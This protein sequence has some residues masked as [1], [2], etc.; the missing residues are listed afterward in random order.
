MR[1]FNTSVLCLLI[2]FMVSAGV[3]AQEN[4]KSIRGKV[5]S[6]DGEELP[7]VSIRVKNSNKG[8]FSDARGGFSIDLTPAEGTLVFTYVGFNPKEVVIENQGF[9][10]VRL[11]VSDEALDEVVVI[12]YGTV[13]K[14]DLTG[15]V[16]S[17]K[18]DQIRAM[19]VTSVDQALQGRAAGVQVVQ[20]S[21]VP[22]GGTNIRVR[23]TTSVNA[24]SEPLYVIDGMLINN[25]Q[26]EMAIENRGPK[27][28]P[29]SSLNP[30]DI[31]SI[32]IL[33]DA[34]ATAIYGSRGAN[35]VVLITTKKGKTGEGQISLDVYYG[36]QQASEKLELLN[37]EQ[38]A[39]LVNEANINAG[40]NPVYV[41]PSTL[42]KGT[43]WQNELFRT[44][45]MANYQLS[46]S[47]GSERTRYAVSGGYF[48]QDGIITGSDFQRLSFRN[49]IESDIK[50]YLTI[51]ANI[52]YSHMESN[53]VLTGTGQI[54]PGVI[55]GALQFNPIATV[56]DPTQPLGYTFEHLL[57]T[58]IAN[59][60][61]EAREYQSVNKTGR[62]LSNVYGQV[63]FSPA[64]NFRS[65]F[66]VD[67]LRSKSD[68][69]GPNGLKRTQSSLGE[70]SSGSLDAVTWI[71]TSTL[72]Y[73]KNFSGNNLNFVLGY[74]AQQFKNAMLYINV[75]D[76]PDGR[77][78][79][80]NLAAGQNPQPPANFES[81]WS[82]MSFLARVN[83]TLG[84]KYLF[85]VSGR[86]DGSS[87]FAE[88][89]KF[90]FFPSAAFA[91][92]IIEESFMENQNLFSDLKFR[93]SYGVTGNQSIPPYSSLAL[94]TSFGEGVFN[95][96]PGSPAVYYGREPLSY[97]NK[98]LKWET[99]RQFNLGLDAA[100]LKGRIN[101]S[102]EFYN[103]HTYDLLLNTPIPLTTGFMYTLL[104]VGNVRNRGL[105][106]SLNSINTDGALKWET[107]LN[108]SVNR[109]RITNLA[110]G[111]DVLLAGGN[112]LREGEPIGTFFG[113]V[114]DGIYQSDEEAMNSAVLAGQRP[115]AGDRKYRDISGPDG[116]P[117]GVI[118]DLDRTLIGS[119][120]PKFTYG[121][122]NRLEYT[123]F[124][125]S[126]F[127]QGSQG[128][129]M[130]NMNMLNLGN[131]NGQQNVLLS[132]YEGRWRPDSPG[133][134]YARALATASD[135]I[136]SSR[137]V[138][139]ASYLR[140]R[141][142]KLAYTFKPGFVEKLKLSRLT[143]YTS[144]TNLLTFT[145]YSGYDPEGNAY[146][147]TTN[148]VGVDDGNYPQA[149][150]FLFGLNLGL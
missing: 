7:G 93:A 144:A 32:E 114:F 118:N 71:S 134:T 63:N 127:F 126:F 102:I 14:S 84:R 107:G 51:G 29:L 21:G 10:E 69:F 88:G 5:L 68:A 82:L 50:K 62:F 47:G 27:I 60:V 100:I 131:L 75:F 48:T 109:N 76:F 97:P 145:K 105:D 147:A 54:I 117:D 101:G 1:I 66:G 40:R 90:G 8:V 19:P 83:Y 86:S 87:K 73:N 78:G 38:F 94:I 67:L 49:N 30:G 95:N 12:G 125:L 37:A 92:R 55:S 91:W 35:G 39:G 74:E 11:Q 111:N 89:N 16:V 33:K 59:P 26:N 104:N 65:S 128:N 56:Y 52:S 123:G 23:G 18:S 61:A 119:A 115:S 2:L 81:E 148:I 17:V 98:D 4:Q 142:I 34:S 85:T 45:P 31:E 133:N 132:A 112:I 122:N 24:S 9:L 77:S 57:K 28:S 113:Y 120:Q 116:K 15:S 121:I 124:E 41:N 42:G 44:A 58:G 64:L 138:E 96:G 135:N 139:D 25:D 136:F 141:N 130:V 6:E 110:G 13:R 72:N 149:K 3:T 43:D 103:K 143:V 36:I 129:R 137:F 150:T 20:T 106:L 146:G 140:L 22:G 46:F 70:A 79:F 53:G 108:F 99:T 80:H